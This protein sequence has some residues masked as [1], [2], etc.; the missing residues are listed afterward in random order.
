MR[1]LRCGCC[2]IRLLCSGLD[3]E[4]PIWYNRKSTKAPKGRN[5]F[6]I[7]QKNIGGIANVPR[8]VCHGGIATCQ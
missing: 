8:P 4:S 6:E 2:K 7:Y 5:Y 3:P 1:S